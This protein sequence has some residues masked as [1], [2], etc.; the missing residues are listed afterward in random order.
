MAVTGPGEAPQTLTDKE[1]AVCRA[2]LYEATAI[3][4]PDHKR[5]LVASRLLKRL[6]A[7]QV[8]TFG[9]Y[10]R[11]LQNEGEAAERQLA[12]DL[13]TTNETYFFREPKHFEFLRTHA[14][15]ARAADRP[16]RVWSA[17]SSSGEEAYTIAMELAETLGLGVP[18]EVVGSDIS[19]RVLQRAK[20]ATY[21]VERAKLP[22]HY[23]KKYCL[24]G[25]GE[26]KGLLR[27]Q[28]SLRARVQ[29]LSVGL[30]D[31]LPQLGRFDVIFL[32]N[33][34][35]YFSAQTRQEV[36]GRIEPL[37]A[38]NGYLFVSHS[39][40]LQGTR[41]GLASVQPSVYQKLERA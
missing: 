23:L 17:A 6:R 16:F 9:E 22:E 19:S 10:F 26:Q 5:S 8:A 31:T 32:R 3:D 30:H 35:I 24:K 29:F 27:I 7:R 18:W 2:W 34:L 20:A 4:L 21:S 41:H 1:F 25:I 39:E 40:N 13:L 15:P 11:L 36:I 14:L 33:V 38:P 37:I 28:R 12:R